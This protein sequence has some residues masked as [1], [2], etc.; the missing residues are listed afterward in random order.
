MQ[1]VRTFAEALNPERSP[2]RAELEGQPLQKVGEG[3]QEMKGALGVSKHSCVGHLSRRE[4]ESDCGLGQAL[5]RQCRGQAGAESHSDTLTR[6]QGL[7]FV[8]DHF[9]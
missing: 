3:G 2:A 6:N 5:G 1:G 8:W 4:V 9:L 7:C